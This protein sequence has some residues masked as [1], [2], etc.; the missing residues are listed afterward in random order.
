MR[1]IK[2]DTDTIITVVRVVCFETIVHNDVN[3]LDQDFF[4]RIV[5]VCTT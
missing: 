5:H 3:A 2:S 4:I 1:L